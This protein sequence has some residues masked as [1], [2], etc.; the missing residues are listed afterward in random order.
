MRE[1]SNPTFTV[2]AL[3]GEF[4]VL[5]GF[6][7]ALL[8]FDPQ[9]DGARGAN[10]RI[11]SPSGMPVGEIPVKGVGMP[12]Q[13]ILFAKS[14][15]AEALKQIT[16]LNENQFLYETEPFL[17]RYFRDPAGDPH[18]TRIRSTDPSYDSIVQALYDSIRLKTLDI[19][20]LS[21][22]RTAQ[23]IE[24]LD[25]NVGTG[26]TV[27]YSVTHP[28]TKVTIVASN[29]SN[30]IIGSAVDVEN[31]NRVQFTVDGQS[32]DPPGT[33]SLALQAADDS[34]GPWITLQSGIIVR[35]TPRKP[36]PYRFLNIPHRWFRAV[37]TQSPSSTASYSVAIDAFDERENP[38]GT[39]D[40]PGCA[41]WTDFARRAFTERILVEKDRTSRPQRAF[42][43]SDATNPNY[44][45]RNSNEPGF[46][47]VMLILNH[48]VADSDVTS[49]IASIIAHE[50]GHDLGAIHLRDKLHD[51]I[52]G[53]VMGSEGVRDGQLP[54]F[55]PLLP[56]IQF[57]LGLP[58]TTN[59]FRSIF[60][61]YQ[62]FLCYEKYPFSAFSGPGHG[63]DDL[64]L[65]APALAVLSE[66]PTLDSDVPDEIEQMDLGIA[67]ADGP[68]G[69]RGTNTIVLYNSGD[70]DLHIVRIE[71]KGDTNA[72]TVDFSDPF[73]WTLPPLDINDLQIKSSGRPLTISFDA[74]GIGL[75]QATLEIESDSFGGQTVSIPLTATG[76][77]TGPLLRVEVANNNLGGA[78]L[79]TARTRLGFATV[80]NAGRQALNMSRVQVADQWDRGAFAL[81]GSITN[82]TSAEPLVLLPGQSTNIDLEFDP[83]RIGLHRG[84]IQVLSNDPAAPVYRIGVVGTG[85]AESGDP[86]DSLQYGE[87]FVAMETPSVPNAPVL[88]QKSD[89]E[90]NWSFFLPPDQTY[91]YVVFDPESGLIAHGSGITAQSG[92]NTS[93][94]SPVFLAS[95]APDSDGDGLP[96]D[97]EFAIGT[98][99]NKPDTDDDGVDDFT[100]VGLGTDPLGGKLVTI[101][102]VG[103]G[104]LTGEAK[105]VVV[106]SLP[107]K[108]AQR[109]A[110]VAAGTN[111]LAIFDVTQ[112]TQPI[113]LSQLS[114]P[115]DAT[116]VDVEYDLGMAAVAAGDSG[117]HLVDISN[118][119]FPRLFRTTAA[120]PVNL[121]E[122]TRGRAYIAAS[123]C[124]SEVS[125]LTGN[126]LASHTVGLTRLGAMVR[127]GNI[128]YCLPEDSDELWMLSIR[129]NCCALPGIFVIEGILSLNGLVPGPF[130]DVSVADGIA[131]LTIRQDFG[132]GYVTADISNPE[133][134]HLI[135]G[136]GVPPEVR[137]SGLAMTL[138][139]AGLGFLLGNNSGVGVF[140]LMNVANP[141]N[142]YVLLNRINLP[143]TPCHAT[144][145]G[146]VAYVA[147]GTAGLVVVNYLPYDT[148][149]QPPTVSISTTAVDVD[150][151]T[152]GLQVLEGSYLP[153][154]V[155]AR[156]DSQLAEDNLRARRVLQSCGDA[157]HRSG[158]GL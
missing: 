125:L 4:S 147:C 86:L 26:I 142:T 50:V 33:V 49:H 84:E 55:K 63:A 9:Q 156:D 130:R 112:P 67:L 105:Q 89:T 24:L 90:G 114:L 36:D 119:N 52:K 60:K 38:C 45:D 81:L 108:P 158:A 117:L 93:L 17:T 109:L 75:F 70:Q 39:N 140:D 127:E 128:L 2:D 83:N 74:P 121:V 111:G 154:Q 14:D 100:A 37:S 134:P 65:N 27:K 18:G 29:A 133:F 69:D 88:R 66:M 146:G 98:D 71:V 152:P 53:D 151:N 110:F 150:T 43:F 61:H 59:A 157:V 141:T 116:D 106:G 35:R 122:V 76:V 104:K 8:S 99:P 101:G 107:A 124:V 51:Y 137:A 95:T 7:K 136:A 120:Y 6:S 44:S 148:Q 92:Q 87:D 11:T 91:H 123:N 40:P 46:P 102:G 80:A 78:A 22:P 31:R 143:A 115:G 23:A 73:P 15:F 34:M 16:D 5:T 118:P 28:V 48:A 153:V 47:G 155:T 12:R 138:N 131:Y 19:F 149:H 54:T 32:V 68:G 145:A 126:L 20:Q 30:S 25:E 132:G 72:F 57:G 82:L 13:R 103:Q 77:S 3:G 56:V 42:R 129:Q 79:G 1:S 139:A 41:V 94:A 85:L 62:N 21:D 96:D 10:M 58:V 97:I 144:E 64:A 135:Q 113:L